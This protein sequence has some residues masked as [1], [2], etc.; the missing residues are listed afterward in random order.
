M[1]KPLENDELKWLGIDISTIV[2]GSQGRRVYFI[3]DYCGNE[4]SSPLA[5][6][7]RAKTHFCSERCNSLFQEKSISKECKV[8]G[9]TFSI[10][11]SEAKK[12]R[13]CEKT[14]CR[15][16][17]KRGKNNPNYRHGKAYLS[18]RRPVDKKYREW[19]TS[20]FKRDNYTCQFCGK[21]GGELNADHIRPWAYFQ[22]LRHEVKNGRTLCVPCHRKTYKEISRYRAI[23]SELGLDFDNTIARSS[24]PDFEIREPLPGTI[25]ALQKLHEQ[26][27]KLTI[28][29]ARPW[30][31]YQKIEDWCEKHGLPIRR[32]IC[33][34]PLFKY[35]IDDRNIEF[36]GN[37]DE[38]LKKIK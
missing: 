24:F 19:R 21:R 25:E 11:P 13:T 30:V 2:T 35:M 31:D 6:F 10:R 32:I 4:S 36:S 15:G 27:W 28:Y 37:W 34:K 1:T 22:S 14:A 20:V 23:Q 38:V 8:C 29:T 5:W 33:G 16:E 7:K 26:G 18:G 12:Y 3:C 17:N 9:D